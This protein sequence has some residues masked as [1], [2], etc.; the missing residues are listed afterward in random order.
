MLKRMDDE[1]IQFPVTFN[2]I[3]RFSKDP[4][5]FELSFSA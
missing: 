3:I 5:W 4:S 2:S 1:C